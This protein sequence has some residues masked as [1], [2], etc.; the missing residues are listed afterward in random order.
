[1]SVY[2]VTGGGTGIGAAIVARLVRGGHT[3]IACG[4]RPGPLDEAAAAT[5]CET[6][7]MD[8]ADGAAVRGVVAD[9]LARHGRI[10]GVVANAGGHGYSDVG[11]TD[12]AAWRSSLQANLDT[13]FVTARESLPALRASGGAICIISSLAGLRAAPETAGYTVGKHAL[14]GLMRSLARD[15]GQFGVRTNAVCPG[16][17]RTPMADAEMAQ[18]VSDGAAAD[19]EAAYGVVTKDVPLRRPADPAEIA[20]VVAFLMGP[21]ATYINGASIVVDGGSHIV[22]VP[23]LA[24]G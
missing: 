10:D 18:L 20:G 13:A 9:V 4:R 7:V 19:V 24:F 11:A 1:M 17:V 12:D 3:V 23:T 22:D 14:I 2:L 8:A 21:D 5:G 16:W 6:A 15:Y